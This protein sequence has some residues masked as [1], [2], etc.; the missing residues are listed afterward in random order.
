ML[1]IV[2]L[3]E[4]CI[5]DCSVVIGTGKFGIDSDG[6]TVVLERFIILLESFEY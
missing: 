1:S 2:V 6:W 4:N 3:F 5:D